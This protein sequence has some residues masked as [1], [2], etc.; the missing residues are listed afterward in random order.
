MIFAALYT[1]IDVTWVINNVMFRV[2][3]IYSLVNILHRLYCPTIITISAISN[4]LAKRDILFYPINLNTYFSAFS[5]F[6]GLEN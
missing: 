6:N 3:L 4:H 1:L 5:R 2:Y